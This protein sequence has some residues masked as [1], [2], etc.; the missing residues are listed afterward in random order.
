[1]GSFAMV[2]LRP[3]FTEHWKVLRDVETDKL[4]RTTK[5][6]IFGVPVCVGIAVAL[7]GVRLAGLAQIL[8]SVAVLVGA[9]VTTF[10][11][12]ANL[13]VKLSESDA[14]R[15][16]RRVTFLVGASAV[17]SLYVGT[18]AMTLSVVLAIVASV[19]GLT[20]N[21]TAVP[22]ASAVVTALLLHLMLN[23][24]IIARR[25]FGIYTQMFM[26]DQRPVPTS[27]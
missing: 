5:I 14:Y 26:E 20:L 21:G 12:L 23:L 22:L 7:L 2:D 3:I 18:V 9:M 16:R 8:A 13:R 1:M 4:P 27:G 6:I 25:L 17:G 24:A 15:G 19:G 10:V 11:F